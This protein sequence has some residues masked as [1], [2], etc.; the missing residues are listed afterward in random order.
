MGARA[1]LIDAWAD[2]V[3]GSACIGCAMPGRPWCA[4]CARML[5]KGLVPSDLPLE[6]PGVPGACMG[7]YDD[8]LKSMILAHKERSAWSLADPLGQLLAQA[9]LSLAHRGGWLESERAIVLVPIPSRR[10]TVRRRGHNPSLRMTCAASAH[11]RS[12]GVDARTLPLLRL[13]FPV[14]DSVGLSAVARRRNLDDA[15]AVEP[16]A[17]GTLRGSQPARLV[18]CDDVM[19][20]GATAREACSALALAGLPVSGFATVCLVRGVAHSGTG[21]DGG[22]RSA[23][24]GQQ[25]S[26]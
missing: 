22:P 18:V 14:R 13:R 15:F 11:L 17:R 3:H 26:C 9:T 4:S 2:L 19:T 23:D 10:S 8:W 20:T 12:A 21:G 24:L 16:R 5:G 25:E 6:I 7:E 1:E